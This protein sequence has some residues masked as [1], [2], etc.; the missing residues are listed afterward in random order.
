LAV[1]KFSSS[2]KGTDAIWL[3]VNIHAD[4]H[5]MMTKFAPV[6]DSNNIEPE[7]V[8]LP[9]LALRADGTQYEIEADLRWL[10]RST[11]E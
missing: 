6:S 7:I 8:T 2:R 3:S 4:V 1:I 5:S 9:T 10:V 11:P